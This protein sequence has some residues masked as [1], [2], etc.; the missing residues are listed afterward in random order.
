[1]RRRSIKNQKGQITPALIVITG[2]FVVAIYGLLLLLSIQLNYSHRQVASEEAL[3][4]AEAGVNYY[5][6]HLAHDP[7]DF[8][9]GTG[10]DGTY[11]HEYFDPQGARVGEFSL[12]ITPPNSGSSI[13][14]I[15]STGKTDDYPAIKRTVTVAYGKPSLAKFAFL[16]NASA[17]YGTNITVHGDIHS[18]N[19]IRMDGTNTGRVTSAKEEYRCGSETGCSPPTWKP[20]VWGSGGDQSLWEFPVTSVDFDGMNF[21]FANMRDSAQTEGLYL[22]P[23]GS[24]GYHLVFDADGSVSVSRITRTSSIKGYSVPGEGLGQ[25]GQGGCRRRYQII[26]DEEYMGVYTLADTPIIF[27]EDNLW[28]EGIV[29]GRTTVVAAEFP[30][31][32][33][34]ANIWIPG[35]ITYEDYNSGNTLGLIAQ[36]DI[37]IARD[38]PTDFRVD[39]AVMAQK[40]RIIRHGYFWWCGGTTNAVR[41]SLVI[42]GAL[43]SYSKSYWNYGSSPTSGFITRDI[44]YDANLLY[45]PPPY[46]P[47]TGEYEFISWKEE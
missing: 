45:A 43:I 24:A 11:V 41:D 37:Y 17:W 3:S 9:D 47:T 5:R 8:Q 4:I 28:V 10:Q 46:F 2:T 23:S 39:G 26:R 1:M 36:N 21:D 16:N 30:V 19:G 20:G 42:N 38:V 29:D 34:T 33:G 40:G 7:E 25:E 15:K 6:W 27:A 18:N 35:N 13:V 22:G 44:Y 12:E 31:T 32:S 14:T